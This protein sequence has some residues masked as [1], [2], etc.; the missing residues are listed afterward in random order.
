VATR[1]PKRATRTPSSAPSKQEIITRLSEFW[2]RQG[3]V[4]VQP[5][6]SEVG[7]GTL[8]PAAT[9]S[10]ASVQVLAEKV[11]AVRARSAASKKSKPRYKRVATKRLRNGAKTYSVG[12]TLRRG[13]W[14]LKT[15][16]RNPGVIK[17]TDSRAR[18]VSVR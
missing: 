1:K 11:G 18:S 2:A 15:R 13:K 3:C 10:G 7:A 14:R 5:Y 9:G 6:N 17:T 12:V 8:N 16:Y 4:L